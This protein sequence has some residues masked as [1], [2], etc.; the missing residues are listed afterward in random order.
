MWQGFELIGKS[1]R[2]RETERDLNEPEMKGVEVK[3]NCVGGEAIY[4][5]LRKK[6]KD[7]HFS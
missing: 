2:K 1:E 4:I 6:K 5:K 3:K 7:R